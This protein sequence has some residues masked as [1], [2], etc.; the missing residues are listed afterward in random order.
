MKQYLLHSVKVKTHHGVM[1]KVYA[2]E[3]SQRQQEYPG[4]F[5]VIFESLSRHHIL[6]EGFN[7]IPFVST[8]RKQVFVIDFYA[9]HKHI[10]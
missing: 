1:R 8:V 9:L 3:S 5:V 2:H 10:P 4:V 6:F 7:C